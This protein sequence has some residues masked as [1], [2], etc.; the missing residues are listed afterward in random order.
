MNRDTL[1]IRG[2]EYK[3]SPEQWRL[4]EEA[5]D[6]FDR[7]ANE[8]SKNQQNDGFTLDGGGDPYHDIGVEYVNRLCEIMGIE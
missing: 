1:N 8:I 7:A 4:I 3:P 5:R 6:D 2:I